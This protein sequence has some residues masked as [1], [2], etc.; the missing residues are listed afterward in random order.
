[1]M[2]TVT[3]GSG[4]DWSWRHKELTGGG[5]PSLNSCYVLRGTLILEGDMWVRSLT[6][7]LWVLVLMLLPYR[8]LV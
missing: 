4:T 1:M 5:A 8:S 3:P 7:G 6:D 2:K